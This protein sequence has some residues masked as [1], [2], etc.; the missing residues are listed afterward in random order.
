MNVPNK[1]ASRAF[2]PKPLGF[3]LI[4]LLVVIAIIAILA[5][6]LFPVFA[7]AREKARQTTCLSN[8]KQIGIGFE[9]YKQ[10]YDGIYPINRERTDA[11]PPTSDAEETIAWP[12]LI[13]PYI[14]NGK[15]MNTDGTVSYTQ[16]VYHC[17]SDTGTVVGPSYAI[18]AWLEFGFAESG[19]NKPAETIVLAEKRGDIEE[20]HFVWWLSPWPT[21]PVAQNTPIDATEEILNNIKGGSPEGEHE[22]GLQTRRHSRGANWLYADSHV[23]WTSLKR[24]W[25]DATTTNQLWPARP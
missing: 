2:T 5:A 14:K 15:V 12:E 9:M 17:P 4:E 16:G 3:T 8:L 21:W 25:G 22:V 24:V 20:E 7:Q 13:E 23:K 11:D 18:N 6:I 1:K 10:D 19:M